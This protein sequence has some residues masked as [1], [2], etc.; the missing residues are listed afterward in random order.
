MNHRQHR[1]GRQSGQ[2]LVLFAGGLI[3]IIIASGLVIDVGFAWA[4]QRNTQNSADAAAKA[5]AVVVGR[6]AAEGSSGSVDWDAEVETAM[7]SSATLNETA[8][9]TA[10]YTDWQGN[11]LPGANDVG[12][13]YVPPD[14]AGVRAVTNKTPQTFLI[15]VIGINQWNIVQEATAVSG[16]TAGCLES[17]ASCTLLPVTFPVTANQCTATGHSSEPVSP[18]VPWTKGDIITLPLCGGNPG[19]VGWLDW[20]PPNGGTAELVQAVISPPNTAIAIPLWHEVTQTGEISSKPLEDALKDYIGRVVQV[21]MFSSTCPDAPADLVN[22]KCVDEGGFGSNQW[23]YLSDLLSFR[24]TE[25]YTNGNGADECGL[26]ATSCLRGSFVSFMMDGE[27][28]EPC[29]GPCPF[30]TTFAVQLVK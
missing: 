21:P 5:G 9:V 12:Q 24:L 20:E 11:V 8:L 27:V 29:D 3:A 14:A 4:E 28:G 17:L 19:S 10:E 7:T 15:R 18:P 1:R 16:P 2:I 22:G 26:N 30:G 6:Q 25:V 13:G 23:Y